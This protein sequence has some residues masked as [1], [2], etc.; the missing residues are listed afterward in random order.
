MESDFERVVRQVYRAWK[1][2]QEA[3]AG[4]HP[5]EETIACFSNGRIGVRQ[6]QAVKAHCLA[7]D[8]CAHHV[9]WGIAVQAIREASVNR[10]LVGGVS[11]GGGV[12][13]A[14]RMLIREYAVGI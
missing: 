2:T 11:A 10:R 14:L 5:D 13:A 6:R 1:G 4:A 7:C 12:F 9:A 8:R 3:S